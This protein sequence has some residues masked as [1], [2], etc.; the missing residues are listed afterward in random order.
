MNASVSTTVNFGR[1]DLISIEGLALYFLVYQFH[2]AFCHFYN[3]LQN[4]FIHPIQ[5]L[6]I[7]QFR[8]IKSSTELLAVLNKKTQAIAEGNLRNFLTK[9]LRS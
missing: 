7:L 5:I 8:T 9:I 1:F 2:I 3:D 4:A 6:K